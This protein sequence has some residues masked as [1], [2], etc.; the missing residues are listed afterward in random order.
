[1]SKIEEA[2]TRFEYCAIAL[3]VVL[4]ADEALEILGETYVNL[5]VELLGPHATSIL[6]RVRANELHNEARDRSPLN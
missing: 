2:R 4:G 5:A 6:L 3:A 1:M